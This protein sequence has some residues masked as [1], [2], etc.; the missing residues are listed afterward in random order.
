MVQLQ[1]MKTHQFRFW[2]KKPALSTSWMDRYLLTLAK[3][4]HANDS[5]VLELCAGAGLGTDGYLFSSGTAVSGS[6]CSGNPAGPGVHFIPT[7]V[8]L[9]Q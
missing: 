6:D 9:P 2:L 4:C 1:S 8:A 5:L 3:M 7:P